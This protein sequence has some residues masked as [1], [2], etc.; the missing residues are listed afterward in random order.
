LVETPSC[1][2]LALYTGGKSKVIF[3]SRART[4]LAARQARFHH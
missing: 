4:C 3:D 2:L 1:E